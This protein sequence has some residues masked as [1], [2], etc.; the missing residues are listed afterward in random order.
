MKSFLKKIKIENTNDYKSYIYQYGT[1]D[2]IEEFIR[3][4]YNCHQPINL[5]NFRTEKFI[6]TNIDRILKCNL[7]YYVHYSYFIKYFSF[8]TNL[9]GSTIIVEINKFNSGFSN[10]IALSSFLKWKNIK[11]YDE[12]KGKFLCKYEIILHFI[13]IILFF[14]LFLLLI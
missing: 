8:S 1:G 2:E 12:T 11:F 7:T 6:K 14:Y 4:T 3:I 10:I 13:A 5:F 9:Y